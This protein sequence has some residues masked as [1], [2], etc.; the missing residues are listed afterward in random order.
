MKQAVVGPDLLL[1]Y[2]PEAPLLHQYLS[3]QSS[4]PWGTL[5]PILFSWSILEMGKLRTRD[6]APLHRRPAAGFQAGDASPTVCC[7]NLF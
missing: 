6:L 7:T 5:K 1:L 2:H 3:K 4:L